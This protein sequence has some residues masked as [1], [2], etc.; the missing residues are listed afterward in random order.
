MKSQCG[1]IE[2]ASLRA[3]LL[4]VTQLKYPPPHV[5]TPC[6]I[7]SCSALKLTCKADSTSETKAA[8]CLQYVQAPTKTQT[9]T[10]K[11]CWMA[12]EWECA[13]V[14]SSSCKYSIYFLIRQVLELLRMWKKAGACISEPSPG[15]WESQG[16]ILIFKWRGSHKVASHKYIAVLQYL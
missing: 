7:G 10:K 1:W 5:P 11:A 8:S 13:R 14:E 2:A 12:A 4:F 3:T 9:H 15:C 6:L 16:F